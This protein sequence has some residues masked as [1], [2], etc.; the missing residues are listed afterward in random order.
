MNLEQIMKYSV[1]MNVKGGKLADGLEY[2]IQVEFD[3]TGIDISG[4]H[5]LL[6]DSSSPR[7]KLA[8]KFR[9][10]NPDTLAIYEKTGGY[11]CM[12][13]D[14]GVRSARTVMAPADAL[15]IMSKE[16]FI[17]TLEA[18]WDLQEGEAERIY[19]RKHGIVVKTNDEDED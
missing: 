5:A 10:M 1:I 16:K 8:T 14:L 18:S 2:K 13:K 3:F 19:N 7:V 17:A 11:T 15:M 12:V 9:N 4:L 6:I